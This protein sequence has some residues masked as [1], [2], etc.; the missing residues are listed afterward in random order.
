VNEGRAHQWR[1]RRT[2]ATVTS[3]LIDRGVSVFTPAFDADR[4]DLVI[5]RDGD[6]QRVQVTTASDHHARDETIV[7]EF[8]STVYDS[9]G[10]PRKTYYTRDELDAYVVYY[11]PTDAT[12]FVTF[13]ETPRT[14]MNFSLGDPGEYC[15]H[16]R[17]AIHFVEDYTL[18]ERL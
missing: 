16:N 3:R 6:L 8:D 12:L 13:E 17:K 10:T 7:V 11:E 9:D 14:Q 18:D 2:E 4:Y 15:E 1:G 5:D